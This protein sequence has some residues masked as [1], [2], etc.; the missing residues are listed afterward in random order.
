M[1]GQASPIMQKFVQNH[2]KV[3]FLLPKAIWYMGD[4]K[5]SIKWGG[6]EGCQ[7]GR[8]CWYSEKGGNGKFL[9]QK[10]IKKINL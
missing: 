1:C 4:T 3:L 7:K 5:K 9:K 2:E 6:T 10:I 8:G